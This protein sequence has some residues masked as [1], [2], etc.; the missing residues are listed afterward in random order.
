M[1]KIQKEGIPEILKKENIA[2]KSETG[3]GKTLTY[4]VPLIS[5]L[6]HIGDTEKVHTHTLFLG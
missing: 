6:V 4:L 2:L 1:T 3:S 5:E